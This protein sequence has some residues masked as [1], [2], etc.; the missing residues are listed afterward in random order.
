MLKM[1]NFNSINYKKFYFELA[2]LNEKYMLN[3]IGKESIENSND[4]LSYDQYNKHLQEYKFT[5]FNK[6]NWSRFLDYENLLAIE[7]G[8]NNLTFCILFLTFLLINYGYKL[9][10]LNFFLISICLI[11]IRSINKLIISYLVINKIVKYKKSLSPPAKKIKKDK[12]K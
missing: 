2:V 12:Q 9:L 3:D 7:I 4:H 5:L 10:S 8:S 11:L 6:F 1:S